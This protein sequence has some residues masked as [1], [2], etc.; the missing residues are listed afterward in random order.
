MTCA[1]F[2]RK[3]L[4][5]LKHV[6]KLEEDKRKSISILAQGTEKF[7]KMLTL[8]KEYGDIIGLGYNF[9]VIAS[10]LTQRL[11]NGFVKVK[12]FTQSPPQS[13][14]IGKEKVEPQRPY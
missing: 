1:Q 10:S 3:S 8:D 14:N 9:E 12:R 6:T 7:E 2:T 13:S 4:D 11:K 5:Y